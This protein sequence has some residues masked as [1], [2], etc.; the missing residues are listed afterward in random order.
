MLGSGWT[1]TFLTL[2]LV[3]S[4]QIRQINMWRPVFHIQPSISL[5]CAVIVF[6]CDRICQQ[7]CCEL[8]CFVKSSW[9]AAFLVFGKLFLKSIFCRVPA[10]LGTDSSAH[11]DL[12]C[13]YL[14]VIPCSSAEAGAEMDNAA[15]KLHLACWVS[16]VW[17]TWKIN[18]I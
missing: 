2:E 6:G 18:F 4:M 11:S 8:H 13:W 9:G 7:F 16:P 12:Q 17:Q 10:A 15:S 5:P 14:I 1:H 3:F